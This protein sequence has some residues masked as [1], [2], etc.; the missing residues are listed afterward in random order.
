[1]KEKEIT[2]LEETILEMI[3]RTLCNQQLKIEVKRGLWSKFW[4][5]LQ[6]KG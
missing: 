6:V 5:K 4:E 3:P 1:M 2:S